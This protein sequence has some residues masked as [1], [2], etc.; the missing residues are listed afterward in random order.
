[1]LARQGKG[2]SHKSDLPAR[3]VKNEAHSPDPVDFLFSYNHSFQATAS[4]CERQHVIREENG[5]FSVCSP[6]QASFLG[7]RGTQDQND[8]ATKS[9][10]PGDKSELVA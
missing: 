6:V 10:K 9:E 3:S 2:L 4:K 8:M 1:M 5:P 7:D